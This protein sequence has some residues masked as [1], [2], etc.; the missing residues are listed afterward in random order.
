MSDGMV[1][2]FTGTSRGLTDGQL[3]QL[4]LWFAHTRDVTA[5]LHHGDC[6]GADA[7]AHKLASTYAVPVVLHP[8][9]NPHK[10]AFCGGAAVVRPKRDYLTRN[11]EIVQ[12]SEVLVACPRESVEPRT[13]RAGGTWYTVRFARRSGKPVFMIWPD[14]TAGF[15]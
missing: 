11:R 14:G 15:D 2:G 8:P 3:K 4:A 12:A 5:Q 9:S 7:E 1:V 10:R 13:E 6:V